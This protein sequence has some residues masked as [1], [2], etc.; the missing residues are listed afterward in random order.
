[1]DLFWKALLERANWEIYDLHFE[2]WWQIFA[3]DMSRYFRPADRISKN[4]NN[5]VA[6][7]HWEI[8]DVWCGSCNY[9]PLLKNKW[10]V[11][12]IDNSPYVIE[13]A[14]VS[15]QTDCIVADIFTYKTQKKFDTITLFE[16][17]IWMWWSLENT[18]K[19]LSKLKSILNNN[20][21]ILTLL[22]WRARWNEYLLTELI[23]IYRWER[24]DVIKWIN[25]TP[26]SLKNICEKVWLK[27]KILKSNRYYYLIEMTHIGI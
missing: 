18:E 8:L 13:A 20:W 19:L 22:S 3:H 16:N 9:F 25:L 24:W 15:W 10:N 4:I 14:K 5:L 26:K 1:M 6:Y 11:I 27:M 7:C 2:S 21:K 12:W 17:N 23:P